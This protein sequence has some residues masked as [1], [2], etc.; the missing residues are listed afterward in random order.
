MGNTITW[1]WKQVLAHCRTAYY[2][3]P[4]PSEL[5]HYAGPDLPSLEGS[6]GNM[7]SAFALDPGFLQ[8]QEICSLREQLLLAC[9]LCEQLG[10]IVV[11][12]SAVGCQRNWAH[13]TDLLCHGG[14]FRHVPG[15]N[16]TWSWASSRPTRSTTPMGDH[17]AP[18][19]QIQGFGDFLQG[20]ST[21]WGTESI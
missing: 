6:L 4:S 12:C 3:D 5:I 20:F 21:E 13:H 10:E 7:R 18:G 14:T 11:T 9:R 8:T 17:K 1:D 16:A 19:I 2:K 15:L